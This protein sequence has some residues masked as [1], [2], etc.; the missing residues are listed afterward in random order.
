M[1]ISLKAKLTVVLIFIITLI[2]TIVTIF[3][4][5]VISDSMNKISKNIEVKFSDMSTD[6]TEKIGDFSENINTNVSE[7]TSDANQ[8]IDNLAQNVT[9]KLSDISGQIKES[10]EHQINKSLEISADLGLNYITSR[11]NDLVTKARIVSLFESI[12]DL[13]VYSLSRDKSSPQETENSKKFLQSYTQANALNYRSI[14]SAVKS[15]IWLGND[16]PVELEMFLKEGKIKATTMQRNNAFKEEE[17]SLYI[18]Q[19]LSFNNK[20]GIENMIATNE[21][22]ALKVY[23][24][25]NKGSEIFGGIIATLPIDNNFIDNIKNFTGKE[26]I[27]YNKEKFLNTTFFHKGKRM[28][29][30]NNKIM[31]DELTK[32]YKNYNNTP[33]AKREEEKMSKYIFKNIDIDLTTDKIEDKRQYRFIYAPILDLKKDIIGVI[34]F[35]ED[36]TEF[37]IE[38]AKLEENKKKMEENILKLKNNIQ[39]RFE[40]RNKNTM[41]YFSKER[42]E[43]INQFNEKKEQTEIELN[44]MKDMQ[45][46]AIIKTIVL[47][48]I[49]IIFVAGFIM[50]VITGKLVNIIRGILETVKKVAEGN[51]TEKVTVVSKD[52]LGELAEGTNKMVDNLFEIISSLNNVVSESS[53]SVMEASSVS[54][55]NK[56][57]LNE[58]VEKFNEMYEKVSLSMERIN[59]SKN[60]VEEM[61]EGNNNVARNVENVNVFSIEASNIA[62]GGGKA[63]ENVIKEIQNIEGEVNNIYNVVDGFSSPMEMI[64]KFVEVINS[65]SEETNLLALN[66][67]IEAARAGEAGK[68][69]AVVAKEVKKLAKASA[70]SANDIEKIVDTLQKESEKVKKSVTKGLSR[71]KEGVNLGKIAGESLNKIIMSVEKISMEL[72]NITA[73]SQEQAANS[74]DIKNNMIEITELSSVI[75]EDLSNLIEDAKE[76]L[77]TTIE[78]DSG[79]ERI[80]EGVTTIQ[81]YTERFQL[82]TKEIKIKDKE[83]DYDEEYDE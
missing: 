47:I 33:Q 34:A 1:K 11:Q 74:T 17:N 2:M 72:S 81:D 20:E 41:V 56:N 14:L 42:V 36:I 25:I 50:S 51:L 75:T 60:A 44:K 45:R 67:S 61:E 62:R 80:L 5:F 35:G 10:R 7:M 40:E 65:I 77:T 13:A 48:S 3:S 28:N 82:D 66:A 26:I 23:A 30:S 79:F 58:F 52:E 22:I 32:H 53:S 83:E 24:Q 64:V 31:Y 37:N 12:N 73:L 15:E 6:V 46:K 76:I 71:T 59:E 19:I 49:I 38:L 78:M 27:I 68:G 63:V 8:N 55:N 70:D 16:N 43:S 69:F 9:E 57:I 18:T 54:D 21:G 29:F 39:D 4:V